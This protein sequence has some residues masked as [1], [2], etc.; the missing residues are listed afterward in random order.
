MLVMVEELVDHD[1]FSGAKRAAGC[2]TSSGRGINVE[3]DDV[4]LVVLV[5][6]RLA[7]RL[8]SCLPRSAK[9]PASFTEPVTTTRYNGISFFDVAAVKES[10]CDFIFR[11]FSLPLFTTCHPYRA[12]LIIAVLGA[13]PVFKYFW[14][15]RRVTSRQESTLQP[16][17]QLLSLFTTYC[18]NYFTPG[19]D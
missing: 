18:C 2:T 1:S 6:V 19:H 3:L 4:V 13:S 15:N 10:Y 12:F 17:V 7:R 16:R 14:I 9:T 11:Q 5:V 8:P